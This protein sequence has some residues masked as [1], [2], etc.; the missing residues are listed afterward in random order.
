[1]LTLAALQ[2]V[3]KLYANFKA[4]QAL[5]PTR[6]APEPM[7]DEPIQE[8]HLTMT[9]NQ[10]G[11]GAHHF[12]DQNKSPGYVED[13]KGKSISCSIDLKPP[14]LVE[15][16]SETYSSEYK[17]PKFQKFI[18]RKGYTREG[19]VRFLDSMGPHAHNDDLYLK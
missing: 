7:T 12:H 5:A 3:L 19:V 14:Y 6:P 17:V 9:T 8:A 1:M 13:S 11:Q 10:Y 16:A 18:G 4:H 2:Q 15:I